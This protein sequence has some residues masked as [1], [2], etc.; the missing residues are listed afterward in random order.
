MRFVAV[1]GSN[2]LMK[3]GYLAYIDAYLPGAT[4]VN[5]GIG[6]TNSAMG[7]FRLLSFDDLRKDD[8]VIWEYALNDAFS[9]NSRPDSW[10]LRNL[11]YVIRH[12]QAKGCRVLPIILANKPSDNAVRPSAYR[13]KIHHLCS[14]YGIDLIDIP[15]DLRAL[16][17][18]KFLDP[19][20]YSDP[21]HYR[22]DGKI[23]KLI[24]SRIA[25]EALRGLR[26][27]REIF[28]IYVRD[29]FAPQIR[30]DFSGSARRNFTNSIISY[31]YHD[32]R[33]G[34]VE[35]VP[36]TQEGTI[37]SCITFVSP[38]AGKCAVEIKTLPADAPV[39]VAMSMQNRF[40]HQ[41]MV[42]MR[43]NFGG[44][45]VYD[46]PADEGTIIKFKDYELSDDD[47]GLARGIVAML[48]EEAC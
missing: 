42:L 19:K 40:A 27:P 44:K 11:E 23:V 31:D 34:P 2:T 38:S 29:G 9:L 1:G 25:Q 10:F 20:F 36:N 15:N 4:V 43:A 48:T 14:A 32:L 24:A 28:G 47:A 45:G 13:A 26:L 30:T 22:R 18:T 41:T 35:F 6:D 3:G 16:F 46:I 7:L 17:N 8:I 5:L 12:C 33:D 37:I 21:S 39:K